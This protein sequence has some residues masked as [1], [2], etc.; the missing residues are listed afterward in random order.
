MLKHYSSIEREVL[1]TL[2]GLEK[3]HH[4]CFACEVS[5][6]TD[7]KPLMAIFRKDVKTPSHWLQRILLCK[8]QNN[9]RILYKLE[10]QLIMVDWLPRNNHNENWDEEILGMSLNINAKEACTDWECMMTEKIRCETLQHNHRCTINVCDTWMVINKCWGHK[11]STAL[12]VFHWWNR[13]I[14]GIAVKG[15]RLRIPASLQKKGL[16]QWHAN[17][18]GV[19]KARLLVYK[20]T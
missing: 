12:L 9:I 1:D 18:M 19:E 4:Y 17:N 8:Y 11:R 5:L 7:H 2:Y 16:N 10:L 14:D 3:F 13:F 20:C 6:I 15:R